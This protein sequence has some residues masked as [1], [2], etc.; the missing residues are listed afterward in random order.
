MPVPRSKR[1]KSS[2]SS[3]QLSTH[4]RA[5]LVRGDMLRDSSLSLTRAARRRKVDPRSVLKHF[6]TDFQKNSS[7]RLNVRRNYRSRETLYIPWFEPGEKIPVHTKNARERRF[8]GRWM[9]ALNVAG[10]G[11]FSK[12]QKFPR[13][14]TIGGVSIPTKKNEIQRI[15]HS[16]AEAESPFEG[17]YRTLARPS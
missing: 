17:L 16:L 7:G 12:M 14:L 3:H 5:S 4:K 11:D 1:R 2:K 6:P 10:R 9:A 15:L 13:D 8:L